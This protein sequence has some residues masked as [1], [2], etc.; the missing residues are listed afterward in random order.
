MVGSSLGPWL[1]GVAVPV[2]D[3]LAAVAG[4]GAAAAGYNI[5]YVDETLRVSRAGTQL[6][7]HKRVN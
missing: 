1:D 7:L 3:A 5:T 4:P 6:L 2:E